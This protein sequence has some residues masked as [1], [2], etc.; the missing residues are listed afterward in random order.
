VLTYRATIPLST[1][2]LTRLAE[3]LRS[4]RA[5]IGS[6]WRRLDGEQQAL[7]ALAH[8]RN[9]D[10]ATRLAGGFAISAT[11]AWRYIREAVDLLAACAPTLQQAMAHIGRL[12]YA[13]LDG[14]LIPIDRLSGNADRRYFSGKDR[15][16]GV[17]TQVIADPHGRL[18]WVS[19]ALPGSVHDLNAA[20]THAIIAALTHTAVATLADKAYRGARGAIGVPFYGRQLPERMREVNAA[21]A[22][23]RAI[24]ERA[25]ATLKTWKVQSSCTAAH[26][27]PPPS[28]RQSSPSNSSRSN[29]P[30]DEISSMSRMSSRQVQRAV[31]AGTA[32]VSASAGLLAAFGGLGFR[33]VMVVIYGLTVAV[34]AW[35]PASDLFKNASECAT[36]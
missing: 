5:A 35:L 19:P 20:R 36:P 11:T 27:A 17:N 10:T 4:H 12:A 30:Q 21:H 26:R 16:H 14:T 1:R 13:I 6:R 31:I 2:N 22:K 15:R 28:C 23:A 9:G 7:L 3:L 8:L 33:L 29:A 34:V 18:M 24:G 32:G 25:V